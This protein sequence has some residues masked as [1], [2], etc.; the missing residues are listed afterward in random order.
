MTGAAGFIGSHM[1]RR[2]VEEGARVHALVRPG[3]SL[4][5]IAPWQ[6]KLQLHLADLRDPSATREALAAA[7]P[8]YV[9]HLASPSRGA[10]LI[11]P[12][13]ARDSIE[14]IVKP[15]IGLVEAAAELPT[16]PRAF[17]RAGSI[18]EYGKVA[19]PFRERQRENP[20]TAYGAAMLAGTNFL[21]MLHPR[22]PFRAVTARL[23]LTYG[24]DQSDQFLIPQ[25]IDACL[26]GRRI[27]IKRPDDRRDLI[28]VDDVVSA[29]LA[30]AE[31][32]NVRSGII[33]VA[34]GTAPSMR[35]V[36]AEV[37]SA[38]KCDLSLV[39]QRRPLEGEAIDE[40]RCDASLAREKY[41]WWARI[42]LRQGLSQL[43]S[44]RRAQIGSCPRETP[45]KIYG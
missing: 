24:T 36:A 26:E 40:L 9:F 14:T 6:N 25:L 32:R 19:L 37:I 34:T 8:E 1:V 12:A 28:H 31:T 20:L 4:D 3:T 22:L 33:N 17:L 2:L 7:R 38:T 44:I 18:A 41:S 35:E 27:E 15:L 11:E 10:N 13:A 16:P 5:R 30:F 29:F 21:E 43:I 45:A 23:A 42:G 39:Q